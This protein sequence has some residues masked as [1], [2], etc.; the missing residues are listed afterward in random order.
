LDTPN[1][2]EYPSGTCTF[3]TASVE[4]L[5]H[6]Y[7][8]DFG[9]TATYEG[10]K[11]RKFSRLSAVVDDAVVARICAG[12]HFRTSCLTGVELGRKIAQNALANFL[13]PAPHFT[14]VVRNAGQFQLYLSPGRSLDYIIQTSSD[15]SQWTPWQT[16]TY[17]AI[18]HTDSTPSIDRRFYR[19]LLQP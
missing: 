2:P 4:V 19:A 10:A 13:R 9:F 16:N 12:A 8:D 14:D 6:F 11:P 15:L 3:T 5:K 1:H 18:L 7:G 17:G